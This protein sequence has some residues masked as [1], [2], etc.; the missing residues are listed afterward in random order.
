M[1]HSN[2]I[3]PIIIFEDAI[4]FEL[5]SQ[6][7]TLF[8]SKTLEMKTFLFYSINS[9]SFR[10]WIEDNTAV[11][12]FEMLSSDTK[13]GSSPQTECIKSNVADQIDEYLKYNFLFENLDYKCANEVPQN[14]WLNH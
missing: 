10:R 8:G 14:K 9:W 5:A 6:M 4:Y 2:P 11:Y 12:R 3:R 7:W 13:Y 1:V